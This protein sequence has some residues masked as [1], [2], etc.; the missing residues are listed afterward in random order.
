MLAQRNLSTFA[1]ARPDLAPIIKELLG[2]HTLTK[3]TRNSAADPLPIDVDSRLEL[4]TRE[5]VVLD[6]E[7]IWP[8]FLGSQLVQVIEERLHMGELLE[9]GI[10]PT[11]SVLFMGPPGVGK[12][13][14]ARWIASRLGQPLLTMDL[15]TVMSSYL[16]RTGANIRA[17]LNYAQSTPCVL[18]LDEFDALAKRRSDESELGE[19]KRLVTV[20]LQTMDSWPVSGLLLA[21]TNHPDLLD[22][23]IWR[24][25]ERVM[26]FPVPQ[27]EQI[28]D[29]LQRLLRKDPGVTRWIPALT[30]AFE[31]ATF[32]D[33]VRH[34]KNVRRTSVVNQIPLEDAIKVLIKERFQSV[35]K[36]QKLNIA[37]RMISNGMS[38]RQMSDLTG[39]SRDTIRRHAGE[40]KE[41]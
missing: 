9:A 35:S 2:N 22:P 11:R 3:A 31:G 27:S 21:A 41:E 1:S 12:T 10:E 38:Q 23:A 37:R 40:E 25:F 5:M 20:L 29:L 32:A 13:L 24:R 8:S 33:V 28:E 4:L 36:A 17:V 7:P 15:A 18:L 39:I 6:E 26:E 16:G 14:A 34:T 19:L 30:A